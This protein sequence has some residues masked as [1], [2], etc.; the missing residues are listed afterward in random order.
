MSPIA[1]IINILAPAVAAVTPVPQPGEIKTFKDWAVGCDNGGVC[2]AVSLV[3]DQ[4]NAF[5]N[6]QGP[7]TLVRT[8]DK[9]DI[10]KVRVLVEAIDIDRYSMKVDG[11]LIDTGPV[12]KGDYP[13]EIVGE[14]AKK[15][16]DAIA[17][18]RDLQVL[19]PSGENLTQISLSGSSAALRYIDA[20]Q[21]RA[22]TSTALIAKGR[23]QAFRSKPDLGSNCDGRSMATVGENTRYR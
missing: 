2:K 17:R 20:R 5:D 7:I 3:P 18:G 19:G 10:L 15:V 1:T 13:I 12:V 14:D 8:S 21:N 11:K 22:R 6:W 9:S 4:S 23:K 16:A